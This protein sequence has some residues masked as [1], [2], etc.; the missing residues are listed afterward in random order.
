MKLATHSGDFHA[1]ECTAISILRNIMDISEI[2]RTRDYDVINKC[3]IVVDVG[4][5][6][7]PNK[8]RFDHHQP[9]FNERFDDHSATIMSSAGQVYKHYGKQYL[10]KVLPELE[11]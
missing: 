6:Y 2:I 9:S 11:E 7:D 10:K 5:E 4:T 1:D 8:M 3:D